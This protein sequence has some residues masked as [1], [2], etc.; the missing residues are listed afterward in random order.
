M[1][2]LKGKR[3]KSAMDVLESAAGACP[4][5]AL[6][7]RGWVSRGALVLR[8]CQHR[9]L[10]PDRCGGKVFSSE[11]LQ[12]FACAVVGIEECSVL[13]SADLVRLSALRLG[14]PVVLDGRV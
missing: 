12:P 4:S 2:P 7:K 14:L 3:L 6:P 9:F 8:S 1:K 10:L 13:K 5:G 11:M